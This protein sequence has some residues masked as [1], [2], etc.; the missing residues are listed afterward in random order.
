MENFAT[1]NVALVAECTV[2]ETFFRY[3]YVK[4]FGIFVCMGKNQKTVEG[5]RRLATLDIPVLI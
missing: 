3:V 5:E 2:S 4:R 1:L